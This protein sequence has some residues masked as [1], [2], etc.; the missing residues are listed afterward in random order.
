MVGST[1]KTS[2]RREIITKDKINNKPSLTGKTAILCGASTGIGKATAKE[3]VLLGANICIIAR[4]SDILNDAVEDL[5]KDLIHNSQFVE[6]INCDATNME[7][8]KPLIESF[9][10]KHGVPEYLINL[11][12]YAL[13]DY[14]E[15]YKFEDFKENMEINYYGQLIPT[16]IILP[17]YL[18]EKRGHIG[19]V[20]SV[21]GY[22]GVM[23]YSAY[24]PTK[25]AIVGLA[26]TLRNELSPYN[27]NISIIF[28]P[29]T[30]TPAF[31]RENIKKPKECMIMSERGGLVQPEQVARPLIE[32]IIKKKFYILIGKAKFLWRMKRLFPN[33]VN[34]ISDKELKKARKKL[35]KNYKY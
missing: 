18:K 30:Q 23:G 34:N 12:G 24:S 17:H 32:G 26:E 6:S 29:D 20:S 11:V 15:N 5:R 2:W 31:E 14:I 10:E 7:K 9:I 8:L 25:F 1:Y 28:P 21:A 35:G 3:F 27:I 22:F 19:F 4:R 16:L 13:P 33:L